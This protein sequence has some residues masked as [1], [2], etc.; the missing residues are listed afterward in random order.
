[1]VKEAK[2]CSVVVVVVVVIFI[3]ARRMQREAKEG[4]TFS[5]IKF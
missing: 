2:G 5:S 4:N 1:L 3:G